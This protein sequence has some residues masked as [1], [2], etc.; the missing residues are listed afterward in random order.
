MPACTCGLLVEIQ[1]QDVQAKQVPCQLETAPAHCTGKLALPSQRM[2]QHG[3]QDL[4]G[5]RLSNDQP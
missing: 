1:E 2:I 5:L 4:S 3:P